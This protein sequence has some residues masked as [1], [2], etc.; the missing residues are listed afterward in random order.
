[1]TLEDP[2]EYRIDRITQIET[3]AKIGLTF[4][5]GLRSI[6]RQDP[7]V[8]LVGEIRDVETAEIAIQAAIT[9]HRVFSTLH[10]NDAVTAVH[11]LITMRIEPV[12][13]AAALGGVMAQRLVRRLCES[14]KKEHAPNKAEKEILERNGKA[15]GRFFEPVGC[16]ACFNTGYSGR[17]AVHEWLDTGRDIKELILNRAS[18]DDLRAAAKSTGMKSLQKDGVEK[19]SHGLTSLMEVMRVTHEEAGS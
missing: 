7:N 1:V 13:I 5:A 16:K 18:V 17:L 3:H 19:A 4:A 8:I 12:L 2:V 11:R 14:C 15:G 9:G 6:L 10:T